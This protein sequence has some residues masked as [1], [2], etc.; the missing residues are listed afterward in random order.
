MALGHKLDDVTSSRSFL[1]Q[2]PLSPRLSVYLFVL[3]FFFVFSF[4]CSFALADD[5]GSR[6]QDVRGRKMRLLRRTVDSYGFVALSVNSCVR[7]VNGHKSSGT[8]IWDVFSA[9]TEDT[10][11]PYR[12]SEMMA[13]TVL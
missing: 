8:N 2:R 4:S 12:V 1:P 6:R 7:Q 13:P 10:R 5:A 11:V 9:T 3:F